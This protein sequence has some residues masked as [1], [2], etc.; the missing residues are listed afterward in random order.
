MYWWVF[1]RGL[2]TVVTSPNSI[3][4]LKFFRLR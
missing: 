3:G 4:S 2:M 1:A